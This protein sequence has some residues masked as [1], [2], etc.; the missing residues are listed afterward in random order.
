[1]ILTAEQVAEIRAASSDEDRMRLCLKHAERVTAMPLPYDRTSLDDVRADFA[2][3]KAMDA[4]SLLNQDTSWTARGPGTPPHPIGGIERSRVGSYASDAFQ[5]QERWLARYVFDPSPRFR[6][7][8][9]WYQANQ[10]RSL[11]LVRKEVTLKDVRTAVLRMGYTPTQFP[12]AVAKALIDW[13]KAKLVVDPCAG[14]GDRLVG[15]LAS[16]AERYLGMDLNRGLFS[17][18]EAAIR[19]LAPDRRDSAL[20]LHASC[21]DRES[22][23]GACG[24]DLVFT[25]PPHAHYEQYPDARRPAETPEAFATSF[26]IPLARNAVGSLRTGGVLALH[27]VRVRIRQ[28]DLDLVGAAVAA[29]RTVPGL[30]HLGALGL[31][32]RPRGN[33]A[34]GLAGEPVLIWRKDAP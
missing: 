5:V 21:T 15:F 25:S 6:W 19:T 22:W 24:A 26:L 1:M 13:C 31:V 29:L 34:V 8:D 14:W 33:D 23:A 9:L 20:L 18:Y 2:A 30:T 32:S 3:L 11:A 28:K 17:G 7:H 4:T 16:G 12:P 27:L 10:L